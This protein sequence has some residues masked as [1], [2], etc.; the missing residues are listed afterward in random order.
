MK[1]RTRGLERVCIGVMVLIASLGG[2]AEESRTNIPRTVVRFDLRRCLDNLPSDEVLRYDA[3]YFISAL[4]GLV[5]RDA[6]R[7]FTRYLYDVD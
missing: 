6:P 4:Q 2:L 7:L 3:L 1:R 5:N